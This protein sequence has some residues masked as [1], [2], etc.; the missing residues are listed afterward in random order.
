MSLFAVGVCARVHFHLVFL[1]PTIESHRD[2][3][4]AGP[5]ADVIPGGLVASTLVSLL[6]VSPL[7]ARCLR[8]CAVSGQGTLGDRVGAPE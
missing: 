6:F 5:M 2:F 1:S 8:V 7:A 4:A 3:V